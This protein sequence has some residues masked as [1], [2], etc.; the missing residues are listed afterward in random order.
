MSCRISERPLGSNGGK[1]FVV[2]EVN[3]KLLP[4]EL[5]VWIEQSLQ[6]EVVRIKPRAGGGAV[7][8]GAEVDIKLDDGDIE[9][10]FLAFDGGNRR[11]PGVREKYLR[12][13]S[14]LQ[15][16]ADTGIRAPRLLASDPNLRV[17]VFAFAEGEDRFARLTDPDEA[18]AVA[19]DF[20]SELAKLHQLDPAALNLDGFGPIEP[21][22]VTV[23]RRIKQMKAEHRAAGPEDPLIAYGLRWLERNVP[24]YEGPT[25]LV[26][27]DAGPGNFLFQGGKVNIVLDWELAHFGD[28]LEDFA[29]MSIRAI[30]QEWVPF[31]PLL[32]EYQR[33]SK[34]AVDLSR[35]RYYRVYTLLGM[36]VGSHRRFSQEPD[37]LADQGNMGGGL[38]F[39]MVHRRAY[40]QGLANALGLPLSDVALPDAAPTATEPY[41]GSVLKQIREVIVART[42][43]QVIAE[44]AKDIARVLKY[45]R[46]RYRLDDRLTQDELDDLH[47]V[48]ATRHANLDAARAEL[49]SKIATDAIDDA[50]IIDV[51]WRRVC[52]ETRV[53]QDSMG[54]LARRLFPPLD[55][56]ATGH[57]S[58]RP[59]SGSR[60]PR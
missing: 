42:D 10:G 4:E 25:V 56:G 45:V 17:H 20:V 43:D 41:I 8:S 32:A 44:T 35:I 14:L 9:R 31:A 22:A 37:K 19:K 1:P 38:M 13:A 7:R 15:A 40:V 54:A 18:M 57:R 12:E 3:R 27:G 59:D 39:T 34:I 21:P 2:S 26:H 53:M 16:L 5:L 48:L 24:D 55:R 58:E 36:I 49:L 23:R 28:P 11:F 6:G 46:S 52:R 51:L 33:L 29:W 47:N 60:N 50:T 30:I